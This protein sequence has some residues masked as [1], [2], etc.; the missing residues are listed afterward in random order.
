M[1]TPFRTVLV[2]NRGEIACRIIRTARRLGYRAVAVHMRD[3]SAAM[4]VRMADASV[5]LDGETLAETFLSIDAMLRAAQV[6]GADAI[7]PGYGFLSEN[8]D[9][10]E[11]CA[12]AG[13][14]FIGPS[15]GSIRLM[16]DK[17]AAKQAMAAAGVPCIPG[18][19]GEEQ[20]ETG[21]A[22][23]AAGFGYPVMI[24]A[25]FGGG[26]RGM[27]LAANP[28]VFVELSRAAKAEARA[29]FGDD[30]II[31]EKAILDARH[32]EIQVFGDRHGNAIHLGERDCSV[33]RRH[34]KL[35]E[36][37]PSPAMTLQLREA[38]GK[39]SCDAVRAIGY[40]GA[41]TLEFLLGADGDFHF[42]E[43]NT[44][45]QVEHPVTEAI[46]GLDLV[47]LQ[48]RVAAGEPLGIAQADIRFEGHAIEARLCAE[49]PANGFLPQTG[50]IGL[51]RMPEALRTDTAMETGASVSQ[52]H[53]SMIAKL[54]SHGPDRETARR[55]LIAGLERADVIGIRT[56]REFLLAALSHGMFAAGGATT[57]FVEANLDPLTAPAGDNTALF[58]AAA[59]LRLPLYEMPAAPF[60]PFAAP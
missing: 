24:K 6:S 1:K 20:S 13:L 21:L 44:R 8:A 22:Q 25:A 12:R 28:A 35:I 36:E 40:E 37:A 34:Q 60:M 39:V 10:A 56:N 50:K 7:H 54:V 48:L 49:D 9:F 57:G 15:A 16:G 2:A 5:A 42:M 29:A 45:L 51:W 32:V 23:A 4:H 47:E 30:R 3:E 27:R 14:V 55:Q 58:V 52:H 17:G 59:I 31:L 53:D 11:E 26:G 41:G 43:M 46:T 18:H 38:M 33:Q 19:D